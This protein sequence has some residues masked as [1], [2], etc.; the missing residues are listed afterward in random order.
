MFLF[1]DNDLPQDCGRGVIHTAQRFNLLMHVAKNNSL[2]RDSR[3]EDCLPPGHSGESTEHEPAEAA[4]NIAPASAP[5]SSVQLRT[6]TSPMSS[7]M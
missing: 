4:P 7:L 5:I 3:G 2:D 6:E 1:F